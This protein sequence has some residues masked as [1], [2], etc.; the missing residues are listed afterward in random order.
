MSSKRHS[1]GSGCC[2]P[3]IIQVPGVQGTGISWETITENERKD[4]TDRILSP[5][6]ADAEKVT[7]AVSDANKTLA[8]TQDYYKTTTEYIKEQ[9]Q[10]VDLVVGDFT[11][12]VEEH[13]IH[14]YGVWGDDDTAVTL[15]VGAS[16]QTVADSID[17]VKVV[18]ENI[19]SVNKVASGVEQISDIMP[20]T[21]V[22]SLVAPHVENI[23]ALAPYTAQ[24]GIIGN[25]KAEL[26]ALAGTL[27][28]T[29]A[30][31]TLVSGRQATVKKEVVDGGYKLTFGIPQGDKGEKGDKGDKGVKGDTGTLES[32]SA[33]V[34]NSVGTPAVIVTLGGTPSARTI[35]FD[36]KNLKG[37][38]GEVGPAYSAE[39]LLKEF[40]S[41]IDFGT[42]NGVKPTS[43][44]EYITAIS[45]VMVNLESEIY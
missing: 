29:V 15:P 9:T 14:D 11:G 30:S 32:V 12:A 34:D 24:I 5:V 40:E 39:T 18:K 42:I 27:G 37:D 22:I 38:Q 13:F 36:F 8:K 19:E 45:E 35:A 26:E 3:V 23:D 17:D 25:H 21:G 6:K 33:S 2:N 43:F 41:L 7:S 1:V 44:Q 31:E 4:I 20:Y 16:I 28:M 10:K